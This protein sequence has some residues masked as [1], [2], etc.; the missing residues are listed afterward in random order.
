MRTAFKRAAM[1]LLALFLCMGLIVPAAEAANR[2]IESGVTP[3]SDRCEFCG[4]SVSSNM[5]WD[6]SLVGRYET[7]CAHF[8]YGT[9]VM[10]R[11]EGTCYEH[12]RDCGASWSFPLSKPVLIK[13]GGFIA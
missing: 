1:E 7:K 5:T 9:D 2:G 10:A 12:C 8:K 6:E 3:Y 4:G 13:C 11:Q